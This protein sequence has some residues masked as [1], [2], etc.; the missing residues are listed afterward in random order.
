MK[1]NPKSL[2][3]YFLSLNF[4][5]L[6]LYAF[7]FKN[8]LLERVELSQ[9]ELDFNFY[10]GIFSNLEIAIILF[11]LFLSVILL[12]WNAIKSFII[13]IRDLK[14]FFVVILV[15][16]AIAKI[17]FLIF[18]QTLPFSDA[19]LYYNLAKRLSE[20]GSYLNSMGDY[21]V[22]FPVGYPFILS[23]FFHVSSNPVLIAK[24]FNIVVFTG[25][26]IILYNL[27]KAHLNKDQLIIFLIV[28]A[29]LPNNLFSSNVLMTDYLFLFASWLVLYLFLRH[30]NSYTYLIL[31]GVLTGLAAYIRP[32]ALVFPILFLIYYLKFKTGKSPVLKFGLISCFMILTI[33]PWAYRNYNLFGAIIPISANTGINFLIGNHANSNGGYNFDTSAFPDNKSEII[34]DKLNFKKA[35]SDIADNPAASILRLPLKILKAYCRFDSSF[36]WSFKQTSNYIPVVLVSIFFYFSNAL[37]FLIIFF[38]LIYI[39]KCKIS[40]NKRLNYLLLL[41][42]IYTIFLIII[43][44]GSD[45][46]IIPLIPIHIYLFSKYFFNKPGKY[47]LS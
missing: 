20:T 45:R 14:K 19:E 9:D 29:F 10:F 32:L 37:F 30:E 11:I 13:S 15:L 27:F 1:T 3:V 36:I 31:I 24:I 4:L 25:T 12:F 40:F 42:L 23:L 39:F 41:F 47:E 21:S 22:Y 43:F 34:E 44:F 17:L 16:A 28:F 2:L 7:V 35:W 26:L 6:I 38:N 33:L 5:F 46:F 8:F 18:V